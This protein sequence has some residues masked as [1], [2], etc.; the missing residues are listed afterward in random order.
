MKFGGTAARRS[1]RASR[2]ILLQALSGR[3]RGLPGDV[4]GDQ[5]GRHRLDIGADQ[6]A[7]GAEHAWVKI[8]QRRIVA[9]ELDGHRYG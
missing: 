8:K 9:R 1:F 7:F 6:S 2:P 4:R 5:S 3:C